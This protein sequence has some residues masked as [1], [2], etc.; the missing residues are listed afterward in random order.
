MGSHNSTLTNGSAKAGLWHGH[1]ATERQLTFAF[2][3]RPQPQP[4]RTTQ[5]DV[6]IEMLRAKRAAGL[7]LELP[8]ILAMGIGQHSARFFEIRARGFVVKNEL[9]RST[10]IHAVHSGYRLVFDPERDGAR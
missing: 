9:Q 8:E 1:P 6:L 2:P 5:A 4:G 10:K 7:A 3:K